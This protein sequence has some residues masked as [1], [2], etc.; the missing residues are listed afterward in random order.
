MVL[1]YSIAFGRPEEECRRSRLAGRGKKIKK[2]L[3]G[4]LLKM[5]MRS[6]FEVS[7]DRGI[8]YMYRHLRDLR[9][10][11]DLTQ[12][13]LADHLGCSQRSYSDYE[14]GKTRVPPDVLIELSK[15]YGT[16]VDYLLDL[17]D[18]KKPYP[19]GDDY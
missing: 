1:P 16:S 15:F 11:N 13:E 2:S 3:P 5:N 10:D 17:T 18:E 4:I 14:N 6:C 9:E 19:Q 12:R 8:R 7:Y